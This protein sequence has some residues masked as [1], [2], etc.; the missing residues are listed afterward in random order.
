MGKHLAG[1]SPSKK[2]RYTNGPSRVAANK[3]RKMLKHLKKHPNDKQT[4]EKI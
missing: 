2:I 1:P 4:A 3:I